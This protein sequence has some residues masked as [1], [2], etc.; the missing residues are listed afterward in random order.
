MNVSPRQVSEA[1]EPAAFFCIAG[2]TSVGKSE[3][4][5]EIAARVDGEIV[6]ADAFQVYRGM[7]LLTAQPSAAERERLPHHLIGTVDPLQP[8]SAG[9]YGEA[10]RAVIREIRGRGKL[11][12]LVGGTG[13]YF[14]A[15]A[16]G[17]APTPPPLPELRAE[18]QGLGID[19]L[20]ARLRK[21]D[22]NAHRLID[23]ANPRRIQRAI[24]I[25]TATGRPLAE[26]RAESPPGTLPSGILL[27]R[28]R[29]ELARRIEA[30]IDGMFASG[31]VEE[32]RALGP[33]GPTAA[34]AIGFREISD[35]LA[36]RIS[37]QACRESMALRTRR[38]AKRQLTW[39][40]GQTSFPCISLSEF[41][42]SNPRP[43][44]HLHSGS[45]PGS[46]SDPTDLSPRLEEALRLLA[47]L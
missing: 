6:G 7:E 10:A 5:L 14:R 24:E 35:L 41:S 39:F 45:G 11:P 32:V 15:A 8:Y 33:V 46:N 18:L 23:A 34:R 43:N 44:P 21:L 30:S 27:T 12:I 13:L 17:F 19:A 20:L 4:A 25:C 3:L 1:P 9:A 22:P 37:T 36:G 38:Y 40:R 29:S 26:V 16:G 42:T 31:V 2:P 28:D 47:R